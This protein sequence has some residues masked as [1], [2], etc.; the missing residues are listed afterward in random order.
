MTVSTVAALL[1][2][3]EGLEQQ[4]LAA[5][6]ELLE[7]TRKGLDEVLAR[8]AVGDAATTVEPTRSPSPGHS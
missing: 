5:Q 7:Q 6:V 4:P 3:L 8:P 1:R 2:R